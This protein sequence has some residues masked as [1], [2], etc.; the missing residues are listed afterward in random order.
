MS[1]VWMAFIGLFV[2]WVARFLV[3][4]QQNLG[5]ILTACLGIAGAFVANFLG[6]FLGFYKQGETAG[7]ISSVIGAI[8]VLV[9]YGMFFK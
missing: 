7:F 6:Q 1:Y 5:L 8:V 4:G 2:G 3:P 9:I